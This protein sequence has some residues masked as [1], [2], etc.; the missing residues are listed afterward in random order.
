MRDGKR[1]RKP[2]ATP[3][4]K[5]YGDLRALTEGTNNRRNEGNTGPSPG[6]KTRPRGG[7]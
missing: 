4:L 3:R 5:R 7:A 6:P 1:D 2:Y